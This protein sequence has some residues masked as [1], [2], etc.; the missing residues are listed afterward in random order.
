MLGH[1]A[2][3]IVPSHVKCKSGYIDRYN[4]SIE[5]VTLLFFFLLLLCFV[6]DVVCVCFVGHSLFV[7]H[8]FVSFGSSTM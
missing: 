4:I 2:A 8:S 5:F 7:V 6:V 1:R 3:T